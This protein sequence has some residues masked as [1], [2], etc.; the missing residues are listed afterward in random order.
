MFNKFCTRFLPVYFRFWPTS[1]WLAIW[2]APVRYKATGNLKARNDTAWQALR[3]TIRHGECHSKV[4]F[5][6]KQGTI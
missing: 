3:V 1:F 5:V 6:V 4:I 2:S